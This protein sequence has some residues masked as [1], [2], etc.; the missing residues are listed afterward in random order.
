VYWQR[1]S[2]G[3]PRNTVLWLLSDAIEKNPN[4]TV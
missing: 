1:S 3:K 2:I 4:V